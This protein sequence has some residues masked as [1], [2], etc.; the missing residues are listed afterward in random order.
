MPDGCSAVTN[1]LT[2]GTIVMSIRSRSSAIRLTISLRLGRFSLSCGGSSSG[3]RSLRTFSLPLLE[4]FVVLLPRALFFDQPHALYFFDATALLQLALF[5]E[6][7][8]LFLE[9]AA[10]STF[11]F[12]LTS[13]LCAFNGFQSGFVVGLKGADFAQ[14]TVFGLLRVRVLIFSVRSQ[15]AGG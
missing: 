9:F 4:E 6:A 12:A 8:E 11:K 3:S 14:D 2:K 13:T 5:D 15:G 10:T 1:R 7:A